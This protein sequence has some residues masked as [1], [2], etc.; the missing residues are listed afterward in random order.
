MKDFLIFCSPS[1]QKC[2]CKFFAYIWMNA[3][4]LCV[5]NRSS[6]WIDYK[7]SSR[8]QRCRAGGVFPVSP[9]VRDGAPVIVFSRNVVGV[10]IWSLYLL[11][12][13]KAF[14]SRTLTWSIARCCNSSRVNG[15]NSS[16]GRSSSGS[17]RSSLKNEIQT[18]TWEVKKTRRNERVWQMNLNVRCRW[19]WTIADQIRCSISYRKILFL[20][21]RNEIELKKFSK[22]KEKTFAWIAACAISNSFVRSSI[23]PRYFNMFSS[24]TPS[25][26]CNKWSI[27]DRSQPIFLKTESIPVKREVR[28]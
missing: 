9:P 4:L 13:C 26:L 10:G 21:E 12:S 17:R 28:F 25:W 1:S 15:F 11:C 22:R 18:K 16:S 19:S 27:C 5:K 3:I 14:L 24:V 6:N 20:W 8:S 7:W 2:W 23:I